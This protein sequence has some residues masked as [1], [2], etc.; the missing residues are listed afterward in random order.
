MAG[1]GTD[2][3]CASSRGANEDGVT[4]TKLQVFEAEMQAAKD[5][6][7]V[8]GRRRQSWFLA[9][10]RSLEPVLADHN[11]LMVAYMANPDNAEAKDAARST[12]KAV[13]RAVKTA[14]CSW[15]DSVL[16]VANAYGTVN[17]AG[18]KPISAQ[19]VWQVIRVR[20]R[21][22]RLVE[23]LRSLKLPK[24]QNGVNPAL[25][26]L[27]EEIKKVVVEY[28]KT[29]SSKVGE[30]DPA[31]VEE[32]PPRRAQT[33]LERTSTAKEYMKAVIAICNSRYMAAMRNLPRSTGKRFW[34]IS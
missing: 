28:L 10:R 24:D 29:G 17:Y 9:A 5:V 32:I 22:S 21:G 34:A 1:G 25:C 13:R 18:G 33:H 8:D 4:A 3:R 19:A 2:T 12:R 14:R 26:E 20:K 31:A 27:T 7:M 15:V 11:E 23:E 30:F 16:A 6:P